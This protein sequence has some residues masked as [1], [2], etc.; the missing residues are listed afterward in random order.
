[1]ELKEVLEGIKKHIGDTTTEI[2]NLLAKQDEEI[3]KFGKS[4]EETGAAIDKATKRI[5]ELEEELKAA[6]TRIDEI[7][8]KGGRLFGG[9]AEEQ[10][11][12]GQRFIESEAY[13]AF[14]PE[15]DQKSNAMALKSIYGERKTITGAP[16][17]MVPGYLYDPQR[18]QG[19]IAGPERAQRVRDLIPVLP[20]SSGAIEFV[21]EIGFANNAATVPEFEDTDEG[22]T[23]QKP[24][25]HLEFE[26]VSTSVKTIAHWLPVTR[27]I[28]ADAAGLQAYIDT[29]LVYG[30][31]LEE[32]RQILYGT[33]AGN[34]LQGIMTDP[35]VQTYQWSQGQPDDTKIDAIRRAMTLARVAEYPVTGV[36]LHPEDW[37]DIELLKGNDGHYIWIVVTVGGEQR[38][39]RAPVVDTTAINPGEFLVGA[40]AMGTAL[41]DREQASIRVSDS[42]KDF[43]TKNL[44][45]ILAEERL[46]QTI[47]RPEAF[48]VGTFDNPPANP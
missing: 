21:R 34:D 44:M 5:M 6:Q 13:K 33:G 15:T 39:W 31:K 46:A 45:A 19:I 7:E 2:K 3:K 17:G 30:L 37:E 38:L 22:P 26:I 16:L 28:L 20:T 10:K 11:S 41:W 27:Q 9:G 23:Y 40:F 47:Y 42:H 25:S 48:V 8:K 29:R 1:M 32:D 18:V 36:V 4:T 14:N 35:N 12:I 24:K 43:F